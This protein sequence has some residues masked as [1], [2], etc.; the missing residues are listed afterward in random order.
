MPELGQ[1][2][3]RQAASLFGRAHSRQLLYMAALTAIRCEPA[4]KAFYERLTAR[5]KPHK[6]VLIAVMRKL[7]GLLD[8]LLRENRLW[9]PEPPA[10]P[11]QAAA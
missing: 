9:Q 10:R 5:G 3:R 2:G 8:T 6:V 4:S 7:V 1:L 11:L